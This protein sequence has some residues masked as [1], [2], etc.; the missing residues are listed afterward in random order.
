MPTRV[1]IHRPNPE[2]PQLIDR[3]DRRPARGEEFPTGWMIADFNL[4]IGEWHGEPIAWEA[5]VVPLAPDGL[6]GAPP[7]S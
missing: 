4:A 7:S 3:P 6:N 2:P 5:W 1:L